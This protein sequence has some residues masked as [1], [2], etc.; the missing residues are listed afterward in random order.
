MGRSVILA[1]HHLRRRIMRSLLIMV[2]LLSVAPLSSA[3]QTNAAQPSRSLSADLSFHF[4]CKEGLRSDVEKQIE[5]FLRGHGFKV[6]NQA[7]IQRQHNVH[8]FDTN[9]VALDGDRRMIEV[10]SVLGADRRYSFG[11]YSQP[12]TNHSVS[13]EQDI[14]NFV[15]ENLKCETRQIARKENGEEKKE[16]YESELRRV[17][18]LFEQADRINGGRH[19]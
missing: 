13:L 8:I 7:D 16:F 17:Q 2:C 15:S 18:S 1:L 3:E 19:I 10:R 14:L 9:M 6:Q 12:P 4:E 11:L 5:F